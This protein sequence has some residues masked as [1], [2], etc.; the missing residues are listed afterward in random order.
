MTSNVAAEAIKRRPYGELS[1]SVGSTLS[2]TRLYLATTVCQV[3]ADVCITE[4]KSRDLDIRN[5]QAKMMPEINVMGLRCT[6][7][8]I[9]ELNKI[10][11]CG[12]NI[13]IIAP[14]ITNRYMISSLVAPIA[15]RASRLSEKSFEF[16]H[17]SNRSLLSTEYRVGF[18]IFSGTRI[19]PWIPN[20]IN[21]PKSIPSTQNPTIPPTYFTSPLS[22]SLLAQV[23]RAMSSQPAL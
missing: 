22:S 9:T 16:F 4:T 1:I 15:N 12:P 2:G 21:N 7:E 17:S 20:R 18:K 8:N 23:C 11:L 6:A 5:T 10:A 19:P 14:K 3:F 13:L